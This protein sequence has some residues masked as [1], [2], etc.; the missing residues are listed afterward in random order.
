M[1]VNVSWL[2]LV[3]AV[4]LVVTSRFGPQIS[5]VPQVAPANTFGLESAVRGLFRGDVTKTQLIAGQCEGIAQML[6]ND[7][8]LV[9]PKLRYCSAIAVLRE[10]TAD[11]AF[12]GQ[13]KGQV[14]GFAEAVGP[15][16]ARE[17]PDGS[18]PLDAATRTKAI[19]MFRALAWACREAR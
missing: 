11:L 2:L 16:F 12:A 9:Q 3:V 15:I 13:A 17:F 14:P 10:E 6:E 1:K 8:Q 4:T 19:Q 5:T 7:G 18:R